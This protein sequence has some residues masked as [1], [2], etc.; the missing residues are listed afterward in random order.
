VGRRVPPP[1]WHHRSVDR[2]LF[3]AGVRRNRSRRS[4]AQP[5]CLDRRRRRVGV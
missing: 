5:L 3:L 1:A 2:Q 4:A